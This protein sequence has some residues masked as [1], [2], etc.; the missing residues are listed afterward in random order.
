MTSFKPFEHQISAQK[1]LQNME[2]WGRKGGFLSDGCGMGKTITMAMHLSQNHVKGKIDLVVCP[3]SV[4]KTWEREFKLVTEGKYSTLVYHG[5]GR[6]DLLKK[7]GWNCVITTYAILGAGEL[8]S[9]RWGRIV[10]DESHNIKNGLQRKCPKVAVGAYE[11]VNKST[12]RFC[13]SATP[14]NNRML[15]IAAQCKFIGT[16]PYANPDW[17]RK[18]G[19]AEGALDEWRREH[20]IRRTKEGM[21]APPIYKDITLD[22]T[23]TESKIIEALRDRARKEYFKWKNSEGTSKVQIQA[24]ILGLIQRLRVCSNSFYASGLGTDDTPQNIVR[25]CAKV[26]RIV[27]DLDNFLVEDPRKGVVIF[28]QFTS[29]LSV[30]ERVLEEFLPGVEVLKFTGEMSSRER[31]AVVTDFNNSDHPRVIL[32]SLL[33]G[34]CGLS[35]HKGSSTAMLCEP[36]YNPF[37]EQQA[38]ERVHR[39]GQEHQVRIYRYSMSGSVETWIKGLKQKKLAIAS[40]LELSAPLASYAINFSFADIAELFSDFVSGRKKEEKGVRKK[41]A[42]GKKKKEEGKKKK[43]VVKK[44]K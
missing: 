22:P 2:K 12:Y 36:Y 29:F 3:L 16:L 30:L 19:K 35:L 43:K 13:I 14:F 42:G 20:V 33:A 27:E 32:V 25:D 34:G 39:L 41:K 26:D 38:E 5:R 8:S 17:W 15:D 44:S 18:E 37:M 24:S 7:G 1:K 10:L 31:D 21:L 28:S 9:R 23:D 4:L 6:A 40:S 11:L